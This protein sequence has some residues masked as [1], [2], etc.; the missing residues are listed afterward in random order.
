M[1]ELTLL[2]PV[3]GAF[4][5]A[6]TKTPVSAARWCFVFVIAALL[7]SIAASVQFEVSSVAPPR[8]LS[9]FYVDDISAPMLPVQV[10]LHLLTMLG[11]AKSR[12]TPLFCVRLLLFAS[13]TLAVMTCHSP[14]MI[15]VL[16]L[17]AVPLPAW[18]LAIRDRRLRGYV[19]Y[20]TL[21]AALLTAA[22]WLSAS[23]GATTWAVGLLLIGLLLRGGIFPLH[24]WHVTLFQKA[25]IGMTTLCV[26]PL[27]EVLASI[28]LVLPTAPS[29]L[30]HSGS[31]ACLI[32][33][34]YCG[35]LAIVQQEV[36]R[37]Y[38]HLCLS[39]TALVMF[40]VLAATP[41]SLTA[42][43]CLWISAVLSLAGLGFA[44]RALEARF[45]ELSLSKHHGYYEQ[46][47][48]L[49]ICFFVTGLATVGFPGTIGFIPMELLISGSTDQGLGIT[50]ALVVVAMFNGLAI[51]RAYFSLFTGKRPTTSVSLQVTPR[52]RVAIVIV[53]TVIFIGGWFSPSIVESRHRVIDKLLEE[54]HEPEARAHAPTDLD[55][56]TTLSARPR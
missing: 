3:L 9:A 55:L 41:S 38:A 8:L 48:G 52:E 35:G 2:L 5:V 23:Q 37:F 14:S 26:L 16:L 39:Q 12:L 30:L 15:I 54:R 13:I 17:A 20:M 43:L 11:T 47:P 27:V 29:W 21:F 40:A 36:R 53:A 1:L 19:L 7:S 25:T 32:T 44:I 33:A 51:M 31:V 28:R 46:V 42:A 24:G 22:G 45:G 10:L 18:D 56:W 6:F 49:A 4:C 50:F 34:V